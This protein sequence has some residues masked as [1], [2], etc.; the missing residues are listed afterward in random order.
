MMR[1]LGQRETARLRRRIGHLW[2]GMDSTGIELL[3]ASLSLTFAILL[4]QQGGDADTIEHAYFFA[5]MCL[6]ASLLKFGG[7]LYEITLLRI[8]GLG[9]GTVFWVTLAGVFLGGVRGSITWLCF[10]V[11]ALAQLWAI[12]RVAR[13]G[14]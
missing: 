3:S 4:A 11:L 7:V 6:T 12:S 5:A 9:L 1:A 10:A 14:R 8:A 13:R 2:S